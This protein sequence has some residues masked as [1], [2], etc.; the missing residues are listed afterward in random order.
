MKMVYEKLVQ[1]QYHAY[2]LWLFTRSD[3]KT[4]VLPST[5]FA[6]MH[7]LA[8]VGVENAHQLSQEP[9]NLLVRYL[10]AACWAWTN[11]LAFSI[12]NQSQPGALEEDRINKPWRPLPSQRMTLDCARWS[13]PF[14]YG[15]A[16]LTSLLVGG[17]AVPS[18]ALVFLGV[19]YNQF[20]GSGASWLSRN[21][22]N[23][24]GFVCFAAG[25]LE[26]V[27]QSSLPMRLTP[28]LLLVGSV[29]FTSV[30]AQDMYDQVGDA[31]QGRKTVPLVHGD[32]FAR[33]A[34]ALPVALWSWLCPRFW[35]CP[36]LGY[37]PTLLMGS[38][39]AVSTLTRST[40][41]AD[42][43]TFRYY[44]IWLVSIYCLPLI[45]SYVSSAPI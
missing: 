30:H 43:A 42:T 28:W 10:L 32:G 21:L 22:L 17:G 20:N 27:L 18:I 25:A 13:V 39:V 5:A 38:L 19:L 33:W 34:L 31:E 12:S 36:P 41:E 14:A 45:H 4:M 1:M 40:V 3:M 15:F 29:V 8:F 44:N 11:L 24:C 37:A 23:A 26:V 9:I 16:L 6:V 7:D 2:T 35:R